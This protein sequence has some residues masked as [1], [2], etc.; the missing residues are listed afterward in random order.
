MTGVSPVADPNISFGGG[1]EAPKA[2]RSSAEGA[3][4]EAPRG[5]GCGEGVSPFGRGYPP[6][7]W[8]WGLGRGLCPLFRKFFQS[9]I[10]KWRVLV[11]SDV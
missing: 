11:D 3:R 5:V 7:H 1:H 2:R 10:K 4:I 6:S 9:F 8:G